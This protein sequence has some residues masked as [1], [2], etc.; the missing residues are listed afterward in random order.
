MSA[1]LNMPSDILLLIIS[2]FLEIHEVLLLRR[3]CREISDLTRDK[4]VWLNRLERL[5][6]RGDTP[7]P[8]VEAAVASSTIESIVVSATR[9]SEVWLLPRKIE[10]PILHSSVI[11]RTIKGL[12]I[13]LDTWLL[14]VYEDGG[15]YLWDIRE[16]APRRGHCATLDL[17][18]TGVRWTSYTTALDAGKDHI[19]LAIS[20]AASTAGTECETLLYSIDIGASDFTGNIFEL[21][22]SF[23]HSIQR[24]ILAIDAARHLLVFSS[25]T[26]ALGVVYWDTE[27]ESEDD[28]TVVLDDVDT[29]EIVNDVIALRFI[30]SHFLA[31]RT[32]TIELHLCSDAF[33]PQPT[34]RPLKHRLLFPLRSGSVSVSDVIAASSQTQDSRIRISLL[35]Y[36]GRSLACYT[37]AIELPGA[38]NATPA[39]D[40][41]LVGEVSPAPTRPRPITR[42]SWFVSAHALGPQAIRAMWI[43]RDQTMTRHVRL[44]TLNQHDTWHEM[45]SAS[46]AFSLSSYDLREDLTH[47]AL[48]EFSGHIALGNRSGHV[49]LLPANRT[50]KQAN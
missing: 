22:H 35:A 36:N 8:T 43:E 9:A 47:C 11:I 6:G 17:R 50:R 12:N 42:S 49:F 26:Q 37:V 34:I 2:N 14:V 10:Q 32:H 15:V 7:L 33:R 48:A 28:H 46:T 29:E 23:R 27:Q 19:I 24:N 45:D 38:N 5:R 16:D 31:I 3:V 40:V 21:V 18:I 30:G 41:T 20:S 44:C 25:S 13:F 4:I 1:F 39:M